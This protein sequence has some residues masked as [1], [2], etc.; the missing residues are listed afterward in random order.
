MVKQKQYR[1]KY[2]Y[3]IRYTN[4]EGNLKEA[5]FNAYTE[6]QASFLFFKFLGYDNQIITIHQVQ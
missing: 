3:I 5:K 6:R 1:V 4:Y 2:T